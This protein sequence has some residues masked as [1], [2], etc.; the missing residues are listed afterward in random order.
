[1][2]RRIPERRTFVELRRGR[3]LTAHKIRQTMSDANNDEDDWDRARAVGTLLAR[4]RGRSVSKR[5]AAR[6]AGISDAQWRAMESGSR[7]TSG[8]DPVPTTTRPE[9]LAAA[10]IAVDADVEEAFRLAGFDP[11]DDGMLDRLRNPS[12]SDSLGPVGKAI[13]DRLARI[14]RHLGLDGMKPTTVTPP[15]PMGQSK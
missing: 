1:M 10:C 4:A 13:E 9:T 7:P 3:Q 6:R 15:N 11:P 5:Q 8:A 12:L 14:E 2:T